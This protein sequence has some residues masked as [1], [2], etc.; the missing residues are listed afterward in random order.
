[1]IIDYFYDALLSKNRLWYTIHVADTVDVV[2]H[3]IYDPRL[4]CYTIHSNVFS[5]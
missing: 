1:M 5:Y 3:K 2:L 4:W